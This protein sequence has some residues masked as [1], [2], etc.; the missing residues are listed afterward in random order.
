MKIF[1]ISRSLTNDLAPWPGDTP[2]RFAL[3]SKIA[4]GSSVNV[5]AMTMSVH[6]GTHA[7]A[8]FHFDSKGWTME[9]AE[10]ERYIG[11][12]FVL[13]LTSL[14]K[15]GKF[16]QI[17]VRDLDRMSD[18]PRL[19]VRTDVWRDS[20]IFPSENSRHRFRRSRVVAGEGS[21][22]ARARSAVGR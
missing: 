3:T 17:T 8:T 15:S 13:D 12:A 14:F 21:E 6:N 4:D 10:L 5:G 19:F 16:P 20:K 1:D 2:F 7:D 11:P 9:E 22:I 18:S